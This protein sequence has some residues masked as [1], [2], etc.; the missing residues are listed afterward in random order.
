M[1][2]IA[3]IYQ[4]INEI[5]K[6]YQGG[7]LQRLFFD[8]KHYIGNELNIEYAKECAGRNVVISGKTYQNLFKAELSQGHVNSSLTAQ[9]N[10]RV[11]SEGFNLSAKKFTVS[12]STGFEV[13]IYTNYVDIRSGFSPWKT[14]IVWSNSSE[15]NNIRIMV[16]KPDNSEITVNEVIGKVIL[17]EGDYTD[18]DLPTSIDGIE[19]VAEKEENLVNTATIYKDA[20][21]KGDVGS[22][23]NPTKGTYD[24]YKMEIQPNTKYLFNLVEYG[25]TPW[26]RILDKDNIILKSGNISSIGNYIWSFQTKDN[27]YYLV[28]NRPKSS[29]GA[30]RVYKE[31]N[32]YPVKIKI[33]AESNQINLPI[34]LRSLPNGTCDTIEGNK[35]IQRVG[36]IVLDGDTTS[37]TYTVDTQNSLTT[38]IGFTFIPSSAIFDCV[39]NVISKNDK[40]IAN[41]P[42]RNGA[43]DDYE[44]I[45][46]QVISESSVKKILLNI[47][48]DKLESV[49]EAGL[50]KWLEQTPITIYYPLATPIETEITSDMI[51]IKEGL[52]TLKSTN[53][54]T[55]QIELDC[56][57]R[58]DFQNL[59]DNVW[60]VDPS[61]ANN[62]VTK[63]F[64]DVS[65]GTYKKF[66]IENLNNFSCD[67]MGIYGYNEN[68][69]KLVKWNPFPRPLIMPDLNIKKIKIFISGNNIEPRLYINHNTNKVLGE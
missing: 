58:E 15:T 60:E 65:N 63:N 69:T 48:R 57:V 64:I 20:Q 54:I 29:T 44:Y 49:D 46:I 21:E 56:L 41:Y 6:Y 35:L 18:T 51:L 50:K 9:Q 68:D 28:Y 38:T 37:F 40:F 67:E 10:L 17:L 19:S 1:S 2:K 22:L 43:H 8:W 3:R 59:C 26:I 34:P 12:V 45:A 55:P 32:P 52:T 5:Q 13:L 61:N 62:I 4:G 25:Q 31:E 11:N 7:V 24:V 23:F 42:L 36:K 14:K 27:Y 39:D 16:R 33:N 47:N 66:Y 30:F 53:N